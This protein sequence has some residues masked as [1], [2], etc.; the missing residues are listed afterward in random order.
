MRWG[1]HDTTQISPAERCVLDKLCEGKPNK[2]IAHELNRA[3]TT[4]KVQ[5]MSLFRKLGVTNRTQAVLKTIGTN[6]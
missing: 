2:V 3:E 4:V 1:G 6:R 5:V